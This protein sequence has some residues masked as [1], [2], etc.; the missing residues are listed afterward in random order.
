MFV[1]RI[2]TSAFARLRAGTVS[3]ALFPLL[4]GAALKAQQ[5][6]NTVTT[7]PIQ[8]V[9]VIIGENHSF[10]NI[11]A[12]YQPKSGQSIWNLLSEGIVN[13]DGTPGPNFVYAQQNAAS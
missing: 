2:A 13:A 12:T 8:H 1:R 7:T 10:D 4:T 6:G 9:I 5:N 3:L 11:F